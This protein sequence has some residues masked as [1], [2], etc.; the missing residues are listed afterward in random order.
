MSE[1]T[2]IYRNVNWSFFFIVVNSYEEFKN[3]SLINEY[4]FEINVRVSNWVT[5]KFTL[6]H[7]EK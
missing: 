5:R 4:L 7:F 1:M 2:T 6:F 3:S